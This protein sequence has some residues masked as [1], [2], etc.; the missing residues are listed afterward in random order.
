MQQMSGMNNSFAE[1]QRGKMNWVSPC[2]E[3]RERHSILLTR[4]LTSP[5]E[6]VIT[7][8]TFMPKKQTR[9]SLS[10]LTKWK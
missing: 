8:T 4:T 10:Q 7:F 6:A 5:S 2:I 1:G 9:N 3:P